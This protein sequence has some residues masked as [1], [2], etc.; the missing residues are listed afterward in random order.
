MAFLFPDTVYAGEIVVVVS[1]ILVIMRFFPNSC[2]M[3]SDHG[4]R[5]K[6]WPGLQLLCWKGLKGVASKRALRER[7]QLVGRKLLLNAVTQPVV[8]LVK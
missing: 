8:I 7:V 4:N 6:R 2:E 3:L 5:A 1:A